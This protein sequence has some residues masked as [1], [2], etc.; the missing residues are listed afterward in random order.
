MAAGSKR[1]VA[2]W[3]V[4]GSGCYQ[5]LNPLESLSAFFCGWPWHHR[6]FPHG[7]GEVLL[8]VRKPR[9]GPQNVVVGLTAPSCVLPLELMSKF[10]ILIC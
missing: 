8:S 3:Y 6:R 1:I 7:L 9:S 5:L 2:S 10:L 4:V